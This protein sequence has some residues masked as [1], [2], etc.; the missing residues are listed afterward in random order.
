MAARTQWTSEN[1]MAVRNQRTG[2]NSRAEVV[3]SHTLASVGAKGYTGSVLLN[4]N[5]KRSSLG[6]VFRKLGKE[7]D[8]RDTLNKRLDQE[9]S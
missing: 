3:G 2:V 5:G 7:A 1:P 9:R 8:L 6:N 4:Q